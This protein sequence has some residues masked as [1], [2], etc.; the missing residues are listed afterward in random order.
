MLKKMVIAFIMVSTVS[1][2][3]VAGGKSDKAAEKDPVSAPASVKGMEGADPD[4][5][6]AIGVALGMDFRQ[7][8]ILFNYDEFLKGF[9]D[10]LEGK[11][12][13]FSGDEAIAI[14]QRAF[15]EAM[16]KR[17]EENREREA[18]FLQ[19]NGA[20]N[21]VVTTPSGL[22]YEV[23]SQGNGPRPEAT[24]TVRVNYEGTLLDGTVFDSSYA[25]GEPADLPLDR[26]IP[27]WS[28]GIQLMA[29]GSTYRFFIPSHLA[30]GEQGAGNVIPPNSALI[31]T[32]ELLLIVE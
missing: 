6:Y 24:N 8:G 22:Q 9:I 26:V 23:V 3:C 4:T 31:F 13:R 16:A 2:V 25:R 30:Y 17:A 7:T 14:I 11:P 20:K 15:T 1:F 5:S 12:I 10:S 27:G 29:L 21:G 32:V 19:E 18:A 28:E